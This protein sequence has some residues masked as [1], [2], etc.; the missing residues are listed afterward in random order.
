MVQLH[1]AVVPSSRWTVYGAL[2]LV[3]IDDIYAVDIA[4]GETVGIGALT[5][6]TVHV[7]LL[8]AEASIDR[9]L[10]IGTDR[11]ANSRPIL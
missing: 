4:T 3:E 8:T 10:A 11:A 7:A 5:G 1:G 9:V 2:G 6:R